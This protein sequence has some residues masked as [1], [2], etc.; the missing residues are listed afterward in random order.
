MP[1][2]YFDAHAGMA[3]IAL[4]RL[5]ARRNDAER[6]IL[7]NPGGAGETCVTKCSNIVMSQTYV[8]ALLKC[9]LLVCIQYV[10]I[11]S[12]T[13]KITDLGGYD[14]KELGESESRLLTTLP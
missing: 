2:D 1:K 6:A 7:F 4:G 9:M 3:E 12:A 10:V 14:P 11:K 13:Q 8:C 5:Q